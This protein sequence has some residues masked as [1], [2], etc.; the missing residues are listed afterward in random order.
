MAEK[1]VSPGVFTEEKDLS[2]LPQGIAGIGAAFV[3]PTTKGP[4]MI[5]TSVTSYSEFVQIFGDTNPNLYLPYAAKEYLANSGQLTVVRT[6]H[7]DG[8]ELSSPL[9]LVATGSFGSRHIALIHPSQVVSETTAFY[10]GTTPLFQASALTSNISGS[11][12]INVSGSY[13]VDTAAF[14]NAVGN[15]SAIYSASLNSS[16][17]NF[18]TKVF[19]KTAN[20][21][22]TPGY[23]YTMFTKAASASLAADPACTISIQTGSFD[24]TDGYMEAQTPWIISQTVAAANQNL[25]KLHTIADGIHSNYE[26]KVAISNIKPAGTVAGSEYGSFTVTIR[27]VDQTKLNAIGSPYTTQDSDVRPSILESFDNVN[28]DPNSARYIAR[29]IGDQYMTFTSGK[30]VVF[31]D[32]PSKSKYVY[33]EVDDNVAKGVYSPELVPFGFAALFNPLPSDFEN[34]PSASFATAQTING[35]Y[36]KRKHFGFEY[37][38]V[39]T[40]NINYLKP[41]PAANATIGSNAK[42]LLSN[43]LEDST[44]GS[45]AIDLTTATSIDSRKFIVPFQGGS[46]GIQSNRRILV[47]ADIVAANTQGYDLSSATAAD[48]SVYK[49]AIDAVSNPDELDI[50][51][52]ALP[53]VIQ[54]AHSAVIDYAANM[55]IDRGDTFLVFDCVGLTGNIAAATSAVEALDNNYAATYYPWVKIVD[56][57]INKPVWVPPSVV[58]PG[59]LAFN[60]RVAAEWYAPAGLNRGGLSTVLDAYTRLTHAERDELYEGRVNPIAT[61]PGQGVCVWGQ[62]TLQAKPSALDR[63]NVRRLLIAVK[64]YIA[65]A[66]KYLVFENNTA[67]TRNR[68]LNI[69]NPYLE[70]VQQRQGLYSFKV[71][72]DETNNTPDIIDRNIMYGQIFL[73]PAKTAEFI[74]IDF[75]ILPTGAAFA[76]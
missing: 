15:G 70:S 12:V 13:T 67:A 21:T 61:F 25:F 45:N 60:D 23:L 49:N 69:C 16:N 32:Y 54:D 64:K 48:Y 71:V 51:M 20:T 6:L 52:I 43:C 33:V 46:D 53:G 2:F 37:D 27:A 72:M 3:G 57:N 76:Q 38:F 8:Y 31:G 1:I 36:N 47:G 30:V 59:V 9:A 55:C 18:L 14:P 62:K 66:T 40:D 42:F 4:A 22:S 35:I 17:A 56:A 68:F 11:F 26:T 63:I 39:N 19:S 41:L 74:I 34:I 5:P 50:N 75:N 29:V 28:L 44:L 24:F 73:Q 65:S 7:D 10:N 58:I